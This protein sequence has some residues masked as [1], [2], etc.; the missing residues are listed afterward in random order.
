VAVVI[1]LSHVLLR[2]ANA[3]RQEVAASW[4]VAPGYVEK[5]DEERDENGWLVVNVSYSYKVGDE[6]HGG[7]ES[8]VFV[9]DEDAVAFETWLRE[10]RVQ[11]HYRPDSPNVSAL[12]DV[13]RAE[14]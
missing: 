11:V 5:I 7:R 9:R 10:R 8:V 3:K 2:W 6:R 12:M 1:A 14:K 13:K 4:P